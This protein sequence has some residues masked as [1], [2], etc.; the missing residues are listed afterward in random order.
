MAT[1]TKAV[2]A[3][4]CPSGTTIDSKAQIFGVLTSSNGTE[5]RVGYL[6][7]TVPATPEALSS[8]APAKPTEVFRAAV[9]C[10]GRGCSHFDGANCRLAAR[11]ATMLQPVVSTLPKCAIRSQCRWFRQEGRPACV[12]CPQ[13]A[14]EWRNPSELQSMVAG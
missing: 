10:A 9:T 6:R 8:A 7:T 11:V 4:L 13:V 12:R 1:A 3:E 14:T 2:T 5:F